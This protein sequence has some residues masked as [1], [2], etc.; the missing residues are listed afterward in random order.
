MLTLLFILMLLGSI[1]KVL[2]SEGRFLR[3]SS[4]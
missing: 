1:A 3:R 2:R 4:D